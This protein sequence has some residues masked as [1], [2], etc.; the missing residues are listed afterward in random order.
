MSVV[1]DPV[2]ELL[3]NILNTWKKREKNCVCVQKVQMEVI[4]F[5]EFIIMRESCQIGNVICQSDVVFV[6]RRA[7]W[8]T[9]SV[10]R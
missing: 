2:N 8:M 4:L 1:P 10:I 3:L 7:D 9:D 5:Y 6:Q